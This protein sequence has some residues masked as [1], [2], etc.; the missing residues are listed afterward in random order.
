VRLERQRVTV[1]ADA[2]AP[3]ILVLSDTWYPGWRVT[4]DGRPAPLL[5][6]DYAFRGVA[7]PAG[8]HQVVFTYVSW[9]TRIGLVLAALGLLGVLALA[10][11]ARRGRKRSPVV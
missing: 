11:P 3:G 5:R 10:W 9:P 7:L 6:A 8:R 4:V 1:D 2:A